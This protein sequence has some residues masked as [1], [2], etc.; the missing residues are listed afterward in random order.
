VLRD[1]FR[2]GNVPASVDNKRLVNEAYQALP[3]GEWEVWL[4]SDSAV[5][6]QENL[7]HWDGRGWRFAVSADV[8]TQLRRAIEE[9]G[10]ESWHIMDEKGGVRREWAEVE[11]VPSRKYERKDAKPFRYVAV[12]L[13]R[14]QGELFG[15]G[16]PVR[17]IA[18]VSNIWEM[19][20]KE[21]LEWH[22]GKAGTIEHVHHV[23]KSGLGGGVYPS[24]KHGANAAWLRLQVITYNLLQL[25]KACVLPEEYAKAEPKNLRFRVF[26]C[27]G[28]VVRHAHKVVLKV[29]EKAWVSLIAVA[30]G[31]ALTV[32]PPPV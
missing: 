31:R 6:E 5:Y 1:E 24:A 9:I 30:E 32:S 12:R 15:D 18:V 16:V 23:I 8:G 10:E 14:Q 22:R 3:A 28:Q 20:G 11:Y 2:E 21:L 26:A 7:E 29:L 19:D 27:L 25:L 13:M 17:Y 4:R